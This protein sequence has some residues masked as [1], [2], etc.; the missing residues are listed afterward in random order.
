MRRPVTVPAASPSRRSPVPIHAPRRRRI[1]LVLG[2]HLVLAAAFGLRAAVPVLEHFH[3]AGLPRGT[4]NAAVQIA[5]KFDPWPPGIWVDSAGIRFLTE[6]NTGKFRVD[7]APD[8]PSGAHL[9]R[10]LNAEGASEPRLFVVGF[11]P[12]LLEVE[13][14]DRFTA[15]Q[16]LTNLPVT[17]SG[18]LDKNGDVD[19]FAVRLAAGQWL[20][21]ALD[22]FTLMSKV[23][24]VLRLVGTN[25]GQLAWNHDFDSFDPRIR[26]QS[27]TDQ[28][29]ILQVFGFRYPADN[30][31]QLAG[32]EGA[33][34]RLHFLVGDRPP[35]ETAEYTA[36]TEPND[37]PAKAQPVTLP[38]SLAGAI[39]ALGD[40]DRFQFT[41]PSNAP[42]STIGF[43]VEAAAI[44]STLDAWVRVTDPAGKQLAH[45]DD[46]EGNRDPRLDWKPAAAG[47]YQVAVGSL[48]Q[49]G[50]PDHRYRLLARQLPSDY[51]A[52]TDAP[53][54]VLKAGE[55]NEIKFKVTRLRGFTNELDAMVRDLPPDIT[56]TTAHLKST[57]S[58]VTLKLMAPTNAGAFSG[59]I[60]I[61]LVSTNDGKTDERPVPY[62]LTSRGENNGVPQGWNKLLADHTDLLWLTVRPPPPPPPAPTNAPAA[63]P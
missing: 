24:P 28:T 32:G 19:S 48:T 46:D 16:T 50:R 41:I 49:R 62:F 54:W 39:S 8:A 51:E 7:I 27:A 31:I 26:W 20:D 5:G 33:V 37:D 45:N 40:V 44:G 42:L 1:S 58:D 9:V 10:L 55:T 60:R 38:L 13:P 59:P 29:V 57:E 25:G 34:Y 15:P 30:S 18:R 36:E 17:V 52:R 3:P 14:N 11:G 12:E 23:D 2:C 22:C 56:A 35:L 4:T 21:A 43:R 61:A 6:T 47:T 63:K 53:G